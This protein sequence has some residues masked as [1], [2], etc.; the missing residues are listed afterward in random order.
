MTAG[1]LN[2]S[3]PL[4]QIFLWGYGGGCNLYF[5]PETETPQ[6]EAV[7][8]WGHGATGHFCESCRTIIMKPLPDIPMPHGYEIGPIGDA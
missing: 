1:S 6:K 7:L 3:I 8:E 2:L 5:H 4:K